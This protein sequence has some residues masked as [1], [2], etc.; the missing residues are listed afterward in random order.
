MEL[1]DNLFQCAF[2]IVSHQ[3]KV[4]LEIYNN[5]NKCK[6]KMQ[7]NKSGYKLQSNFMQRPATNLKKKVPVLVVKFSRRVY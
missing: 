1:P 5:I 4:N 2:H 7:V 3:P 6:Q